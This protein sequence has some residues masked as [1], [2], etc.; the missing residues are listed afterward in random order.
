MSDDV[1]ELFSQSRDALTSVVER[2]NTMWFYSSSHGLYLRGHGSDVKK[3]YDHLETNAVVM[4]GALIE[5]NR[6][7]NGERERNAFKGR[8]KESRF[9]S[10]RNK[11]R[12][13]N[14]QN[15]RRED[16]YGYAEYPVKREGDYKMYIVRAPDHVTAYARRMCRDDLR[17][18]ITKYGVV[19]YD[20][21]NGT[22][23]KATARCE[24]GWLRDACRKLKTVFYDVAGFVEETT[25][26][27]DR[28][29]VDMGDVT[30]QLFDIEQGFP[31]V[32][33]T[34]RT[35]NVLHLVGDENDLYRA[36]TTILHIIQQGGGDGGD[37][38]KPD[39]TGRTR[40]E[41]DYDRPVRLGRN[42]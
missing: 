22:I 25:V 17:R 42:R 7:E 16:D 29:G 2:Y 13:K 36:K 15:V 12:G 26:E 4:V 21:P 32:L 11:R 1:Y 37:L 40:V 27:L 28:Y 41:G 35:G 23:V 19:M 10:K 34:R 8:R 33:I 24:P 3:A 5:A 31:D 20:H 18:L 39:R 9:P 6:G 14:I 38:V 30:S